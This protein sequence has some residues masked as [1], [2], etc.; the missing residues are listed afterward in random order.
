MKTLVAALGA[1][2]GV[3]S[4]SIGAHAQFLQCHV[5]LVGLFAIFTQHAYQ[6]LGDDG[7]YG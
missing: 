3:F 5:R 1:V 2:K 7:H 4:Q 6:P